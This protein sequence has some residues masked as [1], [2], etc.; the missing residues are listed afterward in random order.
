ME[1][2]NSEC[3]MKKFELGAIL[4]QAK[5]EQSA[6]MKSHGLSDKQQSQLTMMRSPRF[7]W[8]VKRN[9]QMANDQNAKTQHGNSSSEDFKQKC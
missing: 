3:A 1:S 9:S 5:I 4:T 2:A 8:S 6:V 7:I